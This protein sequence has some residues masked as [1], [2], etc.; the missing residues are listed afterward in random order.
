MINFSKIK[1]VFYSKFKLKNILSFN[2]KSLDIKKKLELKI[3]KYKN[4]DLSEISQKIQGKI[5]KTQ[6]IQ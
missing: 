2:F 6:K 4:L 3:Q 5:K 1:K